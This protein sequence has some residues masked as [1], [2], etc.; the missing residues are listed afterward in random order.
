M[1]NSNTSARWSAYWPGA[2][3]KADLRSGFLVFLIALPLC[4]GI[5]MASS[6]PPVAGI[7]TAIVGGVLAT[8]LGSSPLTIKGPA[9]GLIVIA[10]GAVQELGGGDVVL[11]YKRALAVGVA[12]AVIQILLSFVRAATVGIAM[13]P[14][15]VHGMLAAIGVIIISKQTH[16]VLGVKPEASEPLELL[17]EIPHSIAHANPQILALGAVALAILFLWPLLKF[18]WAKLFPAPL[19]VLAITVPLALVF[20][21]RHQHN[22][23]LL[24]HSYQVGPEYLVTLPGSLLQAITFPDFSVVFG[25]VS[26]KYIVMFALV[27]SIESTLSVIAVDAMDP[28][29]RP[30]NLNRDLFAAGAGNLVSALIGGLPM[31]SEIVRSKANVDAGARSGWANFSHGVFLLA[32]VALAPGLLHMI[33]LAALGAMLV[34]TGARL[35]SPAEF[36]HARRVGNDQLLLFGT[37]LVV[38]LATDLLIGVAAGIVL[39]VIL[40]LVRGASLSSLFRTPYE[41][42]RE[43]T[44]LTLTMHGTAAFTNLLAI[45]RVLASLDADVTQ[46]TLD[47][48]DVSLVDHTFL[49]RVE[50]MADELPNAQLEIVGLDGLRGA[51]D[52]PHAVRRK[53]R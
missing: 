14:S 40:H 26:I 36:V 16:T 17:A 4:L 21:L 46:V 20:D 25:A 39:K 32:F 22:Y 27:G 50:T 38:T 45:R 5:A 33:P 7:L 48:S 15:V 12:A 11:G 35:A 49:S 23:T 47:L 2:F 10:L 6:F 52:H 53:A 13:S 37:T 28:K 44:R 30:S 29:A 1:S 34:Y 3:S 18:R 41:A 31:I 51:S 24:T 19:I 43:G 9:A 8:F 42:E